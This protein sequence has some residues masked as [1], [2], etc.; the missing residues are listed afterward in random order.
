MSL[1]ALFL[2]AWVATRFGTS[3]MI[4]GFTVGA[5]VAM[6]GEPRR[7]ADQLVGVGEG[8]VVPLFFVHL[9]TQLDPAALLRSASAIKLAVGLAVAA[10][11]V[12][13]IAAVVWRLPIGAG[14]LA[15]AQL[16][17]PAAAVS[18][19]LT[20][21]LINAA[22]GAGVMAAV[23]VSLAACSVGGLMLG[24]VGPLTDAAAP[25]ATT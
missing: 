16:G 21:G 15:T 3:V 5:V 8:F 11:V 18:I 19:G 13:L 1:V 10:I 12:H 24:H 7:V 20:S 17:V 25:V 23:L 14:L 2:C 22:Q 6:L 4:A 9:G